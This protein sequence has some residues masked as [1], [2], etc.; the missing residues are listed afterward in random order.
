MFRSELFQ[1]QSVISLSELNQATKDWHSKVDSALSDSVSLANRER[2]PLCPL[3][4]C[5]SSPL[6]S[7]RSFWGSCARLARATG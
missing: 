6:A 5:S 2:F 7:K 1:V 4:L 3:L